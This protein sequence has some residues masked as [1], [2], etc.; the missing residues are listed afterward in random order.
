MIKISMDKKYKTREGRPVKIL[1]IDRNHRYYPVIAL[2]IDKTGTILC[3][4]EEGKFQLLGEEKSCNDLVEV[5]PYEDFKIDDPVMVTDYKDLWYP[6]YFAGVS[7]DGK[8]MAF[9]DGATSWS[10]GDDNTVFWNY[11]RRPTPE[12][13]GEK[14]V[15]L[16][17]I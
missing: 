10:A 12:E 1:C 17:P 13:L 7:K 2:T 14:D 16:P 3:C 4:T 5:S 15:S 9:I 11:C 8:P 6:R